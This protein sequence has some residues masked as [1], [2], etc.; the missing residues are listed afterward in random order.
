MAEQRGL[1]GIRPDCSVRAAR[2]LFDLVFAEMMDEY[3]PSFSE[4]DRIVALATTLSRGIFT[5]LEAGARGYDAFLLEQ[6]R[7][8]SD[9]D[10]RHLAREIHDRLGSTL[11]MCMRQL[12]IVGAGDPKAADGIAAAVGVL[13]VAITEL[14]AI[15][16]GLRTDAGGNSLR[17][18]LTAFVRSVGRSTTSA[19]IRVNGPQSWVSVEVMDETFLILREAM[20]NVFSHSQATLVTVDVDIAPYEIWARVVDN[21]VGFDLSL[22]RRE[23]GLSSMRERAGLLSGAVSFRSRVGAGTRVELW[24]PL[25]V[26]AERVQR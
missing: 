22:P 18:A 10:R 5:R 25:P 14:A 21:G 17:D 24:I 3:G 7:I 8:V 1:R 26:D 4:P 19:E 9:A 6:T 2:I 15:T 16:T 23:N 20:R 11:S 12:E 13:S